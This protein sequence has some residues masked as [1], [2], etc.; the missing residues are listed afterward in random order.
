L[1]DHGTQVLYVRVWGWWLIFLVLYMWLESILLF[2]ILSVV[3]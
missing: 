2:L 1:R 3:V